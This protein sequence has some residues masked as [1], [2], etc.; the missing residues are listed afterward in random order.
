MG[1][2]WLLHYVQEMRAF[3]RLEAQRLPKVAS[4][5]EGEFNADFKV[6]R[7]VDEHEEVI[8]IARPLRFG[9]GSFYSGEWD[10][11]AAWGD[12]GS[13][14][15]ARMRS[16]VTAAVPLDIKPLRSPV[17]VASE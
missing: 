4:V 8:Q 6:V 14:V 12:T 9:E 3:A 13:A 15:L 11:A 10:G 7:R 16:K 1:G 2:R 5:F 17:E